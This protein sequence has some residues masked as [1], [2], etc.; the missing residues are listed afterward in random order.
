LIGKN[1]TIA[2][3]EANEEKTSFN[4]GVKSLPWLILT[5]R[6]HIVNAEG[7]DLVELDEKIRMTNTNKTDG[8]D[9]VAKHKEPSPEKS[10][11]GRQGALDLLDRYR[12]TQEALRSFAAKGEETSASTWEGRQ[13]FERRNY[14]FKT[15]GTRLELHL[16]EWRD[17][18]SEDEPTR[19]EKGRYVYWLWDGQCVI[20]HQGSSA[21]VEQEKPGTNHVWVYKYSRDNTIN[22]R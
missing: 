2:T 14:E 22:A 21:R 1:W 7:F 6:N 15:D 18:P 13:R 12:R 11:P 5:D 9:A 19:P 16:Q 17:L 10:A 4:W 20:E 3:I 8:P